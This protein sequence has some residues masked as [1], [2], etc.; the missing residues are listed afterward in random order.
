MGEALDYNVKD[1]Q[2]SGSTG[3]A[4]LSKHYVSFSVVMLD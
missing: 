1:E 3:A 4:S 2:M